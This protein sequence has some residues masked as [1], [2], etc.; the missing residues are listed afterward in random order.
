MKQA[1]VLGAGSWGTAMADY[2]ARQGLLVHL[3][4]REDALREEMMSQRE[5]TTFLPGIPLHE[6]VRPTAC[7]QE[8]LEQTDLLFTA[9]PSQFIRP[10]FR[11]LAH[12]E[13]AGPII[14]LSKGF[15]ASSTL[16]LSQVARAEMGDA[17]MDRWATLSGPSFARE[18]ALGHPTAVVLAGT[19][20]AMLTPVQERLSSATLRLYRSEDVTGTE[21]AGS[22]KN[23]MALAAGMVVGCGFG[24]NTTASLVTRATVEITRLG[25]ALGARRET[26]SGLAG[27]GDLMLTC[28]GSLSRNHQLGRKLAQGLSLSEALAQSPMVVEGVETTRAVH[29]LARE[30]EIEMPIAQEVYR[31]LFQQKAPRRALSDLMGR[32]LKSE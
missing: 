6:A 23:V 3:W 5:N 8:H 10:F 32:S 15:E 31:I 4:V 16:T 27:I 1:L 17:I 7:W 19:S 13:Y 24:S 12:T 26:F 25:L 22:L 18:L 2:L 28:F 21:V 20:E 14:N 29:K 30:K 9:V 11:G